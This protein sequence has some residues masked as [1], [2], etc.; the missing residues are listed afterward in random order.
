MAQGGGDVADDISLFDRA[1]AEYEAGQANL[2]HR[3]ASA[4]EALDADFNNLEA[5]ASE[6]K[7]QVP[8]AGRLFDVMAD[9][10]PFM[11][12][13]QRDAY[14][15]RLDRVRKSLDKLRS[16]EPRRGTWVIR[17]FLGERVNTKVWKRSELFAMKD[18]YN[19]YKSKSTIIFILFP[20]VQL[21]VSSHRFIGILHQLWLL[22]FYL[23]L[24]LRESLLLCNGSNIM[25]W[26]ITHHYVSMA[27]SVATLVWH[28]G[29]GYRWFIGNATKLMIWQ[30]LIMLFQTQ[31]QKSRHYVRMSLG[32]AGELDVPSSETLVEKPTNL[33]IL[34]PL[35][36]I[37]YALQL[38]TGTTL[39]LKST[40]F[41]GSLWNFVIIGT[42]MCLLGVGNSIATLRVLRKKRNERR[43]QSARLQ[44]QK[45]Q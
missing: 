43:A 14:Q 20:L 31:Y 8:E 36:Y 19:N 1:L 17:M 3:L 38:F 35:L 4:L 13:A 18:A 30:G 25:P 5:L 11:D 45:C 2:D 6:G 40:V 32:K 10:R 44:E 34:V 7:R 39:I 33:T 26:W 23:S 12:S 42:L 37:T 9:L 16:I 29:P 27:I 28:D 24:S 41:P 22:H 21:L 15:A